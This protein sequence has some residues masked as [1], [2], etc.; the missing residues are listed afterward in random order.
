MLPGLRAIIRYLFLL[1]AITVG[2]FPAAFQSFS[3]TAMND[4]I[5]QVQ[6]SEESRLEEIKRWEILGFDYP[7]S[8][9]SKLHTLLAEIKE[10]P[11]DQAKGAAYQTL[12]RLYYVKGDYVK[13]YETLEQ[14][15]EIWEKLENKVGLSG[16]LNSLGLI[17]QMREEYDRAR[18]VHRVSLS[19]A[20][21]LDD[22]YLIS[23]NLFNLAII[24]DYTGQYA[25]S[26]S[27]LDSAELYLD[28]IAD[29][30]LP[31]MITSRRAEVFSH[32]NDYENAL[33]AYNLVLNRNPNNWEKAFVLSGKAKVLLALKRY[34]EAF[35]DAKESYRI[36]SESAAFWEMQRSLEIISTVEEIRGNYGEALEAYK[37]F[38]QYS[39]SVF[40]RD[41][42]LRLSG[43]MLDRERLRN[44]IL[45]EENLQNQILIQ[46]KNT[47]IISI[48]GGLIVFVV[49][50]IVIIKQ[51]RTEALLNKELIEKNLLIENQKN[52]IES[53]NQELIKQ[54]E[55]KD[56]I[57]SV[58]SH[59]IRSPMANITQVLNLVNQKYL[60]QEE[61]NYL[62]GELENQVSSTSE[63]L[64]TLLKWAMVQMKAEDTHPENVSIATCFE[65]VKHKL[66]ATAEKKNIKIFKTIN[67]GVQAFADPHHLEIILR[68]LLSNAIKFSNEG[69]QISLAIKAEGDRVKITMEDTGIGITKEKAERLFKDFGSDISSKGTANEQGTGLGLTLVHHFVLQNKGNIAVESHPGKGTR[70]VLTLPAAKM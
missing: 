49:L 5:Q 53:T 64:N 57:L 26:L 59:D 9:I 18:T 65:R 45:E 19:L 60:S 67:P 47:I 38:K 50:L 13:S 58:I 42:E 10:S 16:V 14:A 69:G 22:L 27:L 3:H 33:K 43:L 12:G 31:N 56:R 66:A 35:L 68:N 44:Q 48:I 4:S 21:E 34:D 25:A 17:Y 46:R 11:L 28:A 55:S 52:E 32:I 41:S 7:D 37:L 40:N 62:L 1:G 51:N 36:A 63:T 6:Q 2:I 61:Q 29:A 8:S 54:N 30:H 70:F 24:E 20:E 39:D 23:K 15:R